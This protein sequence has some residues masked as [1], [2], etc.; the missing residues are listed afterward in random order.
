MEWTNVYCNPIKSYSNTHRKKTRSTF[1]LI[2]MCIGLKHIKVHRTTTSL[3]PIL[4]SKVFTTNSPYHSMFIFPTIKGSTYHA[5]H[6][7]NLTN[8]TETHLGLICKRWFPRGM[9]DGIHKKHKTTG[10]KME[11]KHLQHQLREPEH[12]QNGKGKVRWFRYIYI[13]YKRTT[14]QIL[15]T[16]H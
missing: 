6:S 13:L 14:F 9:G 1:H 8:L 3:Y 16:F 2:L 5:L 15:R 10:E 4:L 7:T 11:V 12:V